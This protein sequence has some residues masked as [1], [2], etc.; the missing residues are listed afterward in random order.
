MHPVTSA[1]PSSSPS[2]A[3]HVA[4]FDIS[5]SVTSQLNDAEVNAIKT[6]VMEHFDVSND[7]IDTTGNEFSSFE[8]HFLKR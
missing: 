1:L 6:E 2:F 5:K 8:K 4:A 7:R 3:G